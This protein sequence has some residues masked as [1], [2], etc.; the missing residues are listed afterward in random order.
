MVSG[1][2]TKSS[3]SGPGDPDN[4]NERFEKDLNKE[5][6]ASRQASQTQEIW[7]GG[8]EVVNDRFGKELNKEID[9]LSQA[10]QIQEIGHFFIGT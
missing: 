1:R 5:T 10:G 2:P 4:V 8:P 7:P 9:G 3:K 6:N